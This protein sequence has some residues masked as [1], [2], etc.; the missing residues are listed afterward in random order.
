MG[1]V[2]FILHL[3]WYNN[4]MPRQSRIDLADHIYHVLNRANGRMLIFNEE[5][6][7]LLFE[8][9]LTEAKALTDMRII[10]Y[11]IMPN[12]FHLVLQ[13]RSDGDVARF[14]HWL[15]STHTR[16]VHALTNTIGTGHL[17]QG[18]YKSFLV[19]NDE[20][21]ITLIKYV[22]RNP[23]RATLVSECQDWRWGSAWRRCFGTQEEQDLLCPSPTPM[24]TQY[25]KWINTPD[26]EHHIG[27]I[28]NAI[29]R[30][31]PYGKDVWVD[32]MIT[33]YHLE[34]TVRGRGRPKKI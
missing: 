16:R 8:E 3:L 1:S 18:R 23:V 31:V 34:S 28:R 11:V 2:T 20:Y 15:L 26:N 22:E 27:Q 33:L 7:Y 25:I 30:G 21:L 9:L 32:K 19:E 29:K 17:Y 14:M 12:H 24:P 6:D 5:A 10:S 13:P 4:S